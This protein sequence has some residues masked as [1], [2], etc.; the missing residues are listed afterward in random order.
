MV[1]LG[2]LF[3]VTRWDYFMHNPLA[4]MNGGIEG[5]IARV[6][7]LQPLESEV[8]L[9]SLLLLGQRGWILYVLP[10]RQV[11]WPLVGMIVLWI[12]YCHYR[13]HVPCR[14]LIADSGGQTQ[15][16][17]CAYAPIILFLLLKLLSMY[18]HQQ[19]AAAM[20]GTIFNTS[21]C[22]RNSGI[23]PRNA[24]VYNKQ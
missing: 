11:F 7:R 17:W 4:P 20:Y 13:F 6:R 14:F 22:R 3:Y 12:P 24:G 19:L 8:S 10:T 21:M 16:A 18:I 2:I 15:V 5:V 23:E 9:S 1:S